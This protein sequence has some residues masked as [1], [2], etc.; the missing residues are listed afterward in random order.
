M[1]DL[2]SAFV[3]GI[4]YTLTVFELTVL[5]LILNC[6]VLGMIYLSSCLYAFKSVFCLILESISIIYVLPYIL[7]IP[8]GTHLIKFL[9]LSIV[10]FP[11]L[12]ISSWFASKTLT[13]S[14]DKTS[15]PLSTIAKAWIVSLFPTIPLIRYLYSSSTLT[16]FSSISWLLSMIDLCSELLI[17]IL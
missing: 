2:W 10:N 12:V 11:W 5:S 17:G 13:F 6:A 16:F 3:I 15:S 9:S 1:I 4:S 8:F 14:K 7:E